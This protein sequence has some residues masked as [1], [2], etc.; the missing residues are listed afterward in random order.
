MKHPALISIKLVGYRIFPIIGNY[1]RLSEKRRGLPGFSECVRACGLPD[2]LGLVPVGLWACGAINAHY[3][4]IINTLQ[5]ILNVNMLRLA[6]T[7]ARQRSIPLPAPTPT[8]GLGSPPPARA[9][10]WVPPSPAG[11]K[12]L[13]SYISPAR[14]GGKAGFSMIL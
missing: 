13:L 9:S 6:S 5:P 3:A 8:P 10:A 14:F 4:C 12:T 7:V 11:A 1:Q 2:Y